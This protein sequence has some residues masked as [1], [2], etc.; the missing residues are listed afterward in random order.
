MGKLV[1]GTVQFGLQYGVN[2]AGRP[3]ED[4]VREILSAAWAGGIDTLDTSSAYGEAEEVLGRCSRDTFKIVSKYPQ[5]KV[6]VR[7]C[8]EQSLRRLD[9]D[10]LYGYLLHHFS[11]FK[12]NP[13]VWEEFM[14]LKA[15]GK[16]QK[17]GFSLYDSQEL[18]MIME[19]GVPFDLLQFPFNILDRKFLPY[20]PQLH[21]M[22]VEI[23]VRSTFLQG[24]F[25]MDRDALP[26]KLQPLRRYLR[27]I[28]DYAHETGLS[29]AEVALNANLQ[30]PYI[31]G[32]L[33]GVDNLAQLNSNLSAIKDC[34]VSL[35]IDVKEQELLNPVN[36]K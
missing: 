5:G 31:D 8:F 12:E 17:I 20:M 24:L 27:Q 26:Q 2:S 30:N 11:V 29:M 32:V 6:P 10:H 16:V 13:G 25:F 4:A 23:H 9:T 22:G 15:E 36:W 28:D 21:Q 7:A 19:A 3:S 33:I 18:E 14:T 35:D 34:P 1:L